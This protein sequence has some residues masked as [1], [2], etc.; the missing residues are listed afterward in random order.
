LP[1]LLGASSAL[2]V[3]ARIRKQR[4]TQN[5]QRSNQRT[6][7]VCLAGDFPVFTKPLPLKRIPY[8]VM[9]G[10]PPTCTS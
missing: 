8:L 3:Y 10:K 9:T 4:K 5:R 1:L 6:V 7:S 2:G